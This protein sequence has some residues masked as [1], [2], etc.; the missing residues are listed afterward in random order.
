LNEGRRN[1]RDYFQ[2]KGFFDVNVDFGQN[3]ST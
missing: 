1:I 2:T 3:K